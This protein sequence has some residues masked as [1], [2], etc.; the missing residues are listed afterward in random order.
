MKE[1]N[2]NNHKFNLN[3][4][5]YLDSSNEMSSVYD[6]FSETKTSIEPSLIDID[7]HKYNNLDEIELGSEI[8]CPVNNCFENC[9]IELNPAYFDISFDCGKHNNKINILDYV[10]NSGHIKDDIE[11][12][13][14][15][16]E[17]CKDIINDNK[18]IYKCSC[19]ITVCESCKEKHLQKYNN[20]H[21]LIDFKVKDYTCSCSK[22]Q[23]K[24][25]N[26]C[27]D[28]NK[29][30]CILC[31]EKHKNH[32]KKRYSSIF[33]MN[34][35]IKQILQKKIEEQKRSIAKFNIIIDSWLNRTKEII[36]EYK[37]KLE[38]YIQINDKIINE[39]E[40][41]NIYYNAI[42]NI[43]YMRFDFD[44]F[45]V[46]FL[47]AEKNY[48]QQNIL[49]MNLLNEYI[50]DYNEKKTDIIN[51]NIPKKISKLKYNYE[52][53]DKVH[54]I[55]ELKKEGLLA[56]SIINIE[57]NIERL[58]IYKKSD[59]YNFNEIYSSRDENERILSLSEL[60]N[61]NLLMLQNYFFKI[62]E[63]TKK[64]QLIKP[65]QIEEI[66]NQ[67]G[68]FKQMIEL[69]NG[70]L[71]SLND[72][73]IIIWK[74]NLI[75]DKYVIFKK[76]NANVNAL[77]LIELDKFH[78]LL[79]C[80]NIKL[81]IYDLS[82]EQPQCLSYNDLQ[83][84]INF[85]KIINLGNGYIFILYTRQ[86]LLINLSNCQCIRKTR[87]FYFYD[88]CNSHFSNN[89]LLASIYDENSNYNGIY[90]ITCD[91]SRIDFTEEKYSD[92]LSNEKINYIYQL[93]NKNII[94]VYRRQLDIWE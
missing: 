85:K 10:Y 62:F 46:D 67:I 56:I 38:L 23:K 49:I 79:F 76:N 20:S 5:N 65:I 92:S 55:C 91:F 83:N 71:A 90:K 45:F 66:N 33:Q 82:G 39:Y 19:K 81:Y 2:Y 70:C 34:K 13:K 27:F 53:Q 86:L 68:H 50:K 58:N 11:I 89:I 3:I 41:P 35:D 60:K 94:T 6:E 61:G 84:D 52:F 17:K 88:I 47:K 57:D 59:N 32:D 93:D 21:I 64:Y 73:N 4:S 51:K 8:R 63:I 75:K 42:K 44:N 69:T 28:C 80:R 9:I 48:K 30:I 12:C 87:P 24:Y 14:I 37:K 16:K 29:D 78:Y 54:H 77:S 31:S 74:K 25:I 15:C 40:P 36:N 18:K 43:Q 1:E 7:T 22:D 72:N 26:Y